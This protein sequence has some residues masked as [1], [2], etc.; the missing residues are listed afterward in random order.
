M[1]VRNG[2]AVLA[3]GLGT[4][5]FGATELEVRRFGVFDDW[6]AFHVQEGD[7]HLCFAETRLSRSAASGGRENLDGLALQVTT[8]SKGHSGYMVRLGAFGKTVG[9]VLGVGDLARKV[10]AMRLSFGDPNGRGHALDFGDT[11]TPR[12]A[13]G[14]ADVVQE[15]LLAEEANMDAHLRIGRWDEDGAEIIGKYSLHGLSSVLN[16]LRETCPSP[17]DGSM[18]A[19]IYITPS[20]WSS[21]PPELPADT[22]GE[23]VEREL[24][25]WLADEPYS[26]FDIVSQSF[27]MGKAEES[28]TVRTVVT[29][30]GLDSHYYGNNIDAEDVPW[31]VSEAQVGVELYRAG[32]LLG[33]KDYGY[34]SYIIGACVSE[35]R[36]LKLLFTDWGGGT[37]GPVYSALS[38]APG[39][40]LSVDVISSYMDVP[41]SLTEC[42]EHQSE[43]E[44]EGA[45]TPC[46]C[47]DRNSDYAYGV[48]LRSWRTDFGSATDDVE[49]LAPVLAEL[50]ALLPF[51]MWDATHD[52]S[53][54]Y[55]HSRAYAVAEVYYDDLAHLYRGFQLVY[56]RRVG[57]PVWS[58]IHQARLYDID[59]EVIEIHGFVNTHTLKLSGSHAGRE[60]H[61]LVDLS[62]LLSPARATSGIA[63]KHD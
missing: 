7:L 22:S 45:F 43:W 42:E 50:E 51:V 56:A 54:N 40:R 32:K 11:E 57:A 24:R 52:V 47:V 48:R 19:P 15:M 27:F 20:R 14:Y 5:S 63:P 28:L 2:L 3:V 18:P 13:Q 33:T 38:Y 49:T 41:V 29:E 9:D 55:F 17:S 62:E 60:E 26:E 21:P 25:A 39:D 59:D 44:R 10:F 30:S 31:I 61:Q 6:N 1:K 37:V 35:G 58:V 34:R 12:W 8:Q 4:S 46:R 36:Q 16:G 53:L 23:E